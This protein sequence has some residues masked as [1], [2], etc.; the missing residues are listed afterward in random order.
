MAVAGVHH[1]NKAQGVT[2]PFDLI[3]GSNGFAASADTTLIL[4]RDGQ[5]VRLY[6]RLPPMVALWSRRHSA[7]VP[8]LPQRPASAPLL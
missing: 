4:D 2:D 8:A 5:G 6:G 7:A 3:S 1:L